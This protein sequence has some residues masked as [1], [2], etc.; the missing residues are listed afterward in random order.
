MKIRIA[1]AMW[2]CTVTQKIITALHSS[3]LLVEISLL[4]V[5]YRCLT[6]TFCNFVTSV[7]IVVTSFDIDISVVLCRDNE[8]KRK[9]RELLGQLAQQE[10]EVKAF[11]KAKHSD[12]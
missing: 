5:F 2:F 8:R 10:G 3:N 6:M 4:V 12:S 7:M 9:V 1:F 11:K